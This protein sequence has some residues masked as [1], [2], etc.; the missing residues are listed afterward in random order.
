[1]DVCFFLLK[2]D[3]IQKR[4]LSLAKFR[5]FP[6]VYWFVNLTLTNKRSSKDLQGLICPCMP[7][8]RR[9]V[10]LTKIQATSLRVLNSNQK[11]ATRCLFSRYAENRSQCHFTL[12]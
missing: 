5:L 9:L 1:M 11:H 12:H 4:C 2:V 3:N 10:D 7:Q 8:L 6:L